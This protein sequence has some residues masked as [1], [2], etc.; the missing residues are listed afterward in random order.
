[1]ATVS[2]FVDDAVRGRLPHICVETGLPA[3]GKLVVE[4]SRGGI[5]FAWLLIFLG[6][7]GWI[8][9]VVV[10]VLARRETLAVRAPVLRSR[11]RP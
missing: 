7:I 1:M 9:L 11:A 4:Q 2:V 6:P 3:D 10:A 8:A 5:G